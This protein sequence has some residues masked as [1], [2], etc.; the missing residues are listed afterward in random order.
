MARN[1]ETQP[2]LKILPVT[3]ERWDDLQ[4]LFGRNGACGGCWCMWWR[5][6][7]SEF[8][9]RKGEANRRSLKKIVKSGAV[10]GLL[11]YWGTDPVGWCA[12]APRE[13][14]PGLD[15]SRTLKPVDGQHVWSVTCFFIARPFRRRGVSL[16]LLRAAV[17]YAGAQG[18]RIVEGYPVVPK[19]SGMPDV[20]A[21]TGLHS[22]FTA[23]G[24]HEVL[25]RSPSRPIMRHMIDSKRGL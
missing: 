18:A 14:Y 21:W 3:A 16:Q 11:A 13:S 17:D 7:R 19:K 2:A 20:F 5:L 9:K 24:F 6:K 10:P 15:R 4:S 22:C 1:S 12:V 8:D 25:R 23:A